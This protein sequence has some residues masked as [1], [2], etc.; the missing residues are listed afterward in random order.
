MDGPRRSRPDDSTRRRQCGFLT[1]GL[2][3]AGATLGG[4]VLFDPN[5][6]AVLLGRSLG[7]RHAIGAAG[8]LGD[9]DGL[10]ADAAF[11]IVPFA[12]RLAA[13]AGRDPVVLQDENPDDRDAEQAEED[14]R[15]AGKGQETLHLVV[16]WIGIEATA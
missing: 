12:G 8:D 4:E 11:H 15:Q 5:Q 3:G 2:C 13:F 1:L 6:L 14:H 16:R 9:G 10:G 7:A